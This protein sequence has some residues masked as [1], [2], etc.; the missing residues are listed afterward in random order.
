MGFGGRMERRKYFAALY[1]RSTRCTYIDCLSRNASDCLITFD[2]SPQTL[3]PTAHSTTTN[4]D[5][6]KTFIS[7]V[8]FTF[9]TE[10]AAYYQ[11][12]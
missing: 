6:G 12:Q 5:L 1:N 10:L 9:V 4:T 11:T 7:H 3:K 2:C 8:S